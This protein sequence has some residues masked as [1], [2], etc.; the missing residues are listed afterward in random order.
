[1][2]TTR[3][4]TSLLIATYA[5]KGIMYV[6]FVETFNVAEFELLVTE[7]LGKSIW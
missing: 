1:M 3:L 7:F 2:L 4:G 6:S 5:M